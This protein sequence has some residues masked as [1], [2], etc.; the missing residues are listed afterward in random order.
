MF[1]SKDASIF[2]FKFGIH[3]LPHEVDADPYTK[4]PKSILDLI[5]ELYSISKDLL[6]APKLVLE[7]HL[8][9]LSGLKHLTFN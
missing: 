6:S 5:R 9:K 3:Y 2:S 8:K 4:D 1:G 7:I